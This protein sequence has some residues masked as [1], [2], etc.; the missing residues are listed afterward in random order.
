MSYA[1]RKGDFDRYFRPLA[2]RTK[3]YVQSEEERLADERA[4]QVASLVALAVILAP[5]LLV[6][7]LA[8]K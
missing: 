4:A 8:N 6:A 1:A 2:D 5:V 7:A 3:I